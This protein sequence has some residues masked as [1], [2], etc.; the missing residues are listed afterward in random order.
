MVK[1][2]A[3]ITTLLLITAKAFAQDTTDIS[4]MLEEELKANDKNK[5][6]YTTATFKTTTLLTVIRWK[7]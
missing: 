1:K 6:S 4:K 3:V 5:T 7:M 2:I